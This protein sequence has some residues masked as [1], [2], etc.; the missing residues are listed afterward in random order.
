VVE[1]LSP[2]DRPG[3]VLAKIGD[4]L[5]AGCRLVWVVDPRRRHVRV[6]RGDG[7]ESL[8]A[9]SETLN[10]EDVIPGFACPVGSFLRT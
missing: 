4:W 7:T 8:V 10:G 9:D 5:Q 3:E 6:Y 2:S 1:V